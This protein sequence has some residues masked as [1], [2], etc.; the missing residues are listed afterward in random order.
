MHTTLT[1]TLFGYPVNLGHVNFA[2]TKPYQVDQL[3]LTT[4]TKLL[5]NLEYFCI[6]ELSDI[7]RGLSNRKELVF[8]LERMVE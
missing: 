2:S 7:D 8:C 1:I 5:V 4:M 3:F 6:R